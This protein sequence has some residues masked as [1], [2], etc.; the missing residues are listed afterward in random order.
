MRT[1]LL[2]NTFD[3]QGVIYKQFLPAG[4]TVNFITGAGKFIEAY[5]ESGATI[6]RGAGDI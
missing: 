1:K 3:K 6:L 2:L 5:F 4:K